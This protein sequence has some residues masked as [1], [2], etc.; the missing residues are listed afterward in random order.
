LQE[1]RLHSDQATDDP[2]P[3]PGTCVR[4]TPRGRNFAHK[5]FCPGGYG[6]AWD[7]MGVNGL[8]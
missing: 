6:I 8:T 7:F 5:I 2:L 1:P 4:L 3:E